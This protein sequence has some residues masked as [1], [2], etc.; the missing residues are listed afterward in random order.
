MNLKYPESGSQATPIVCRKLYGGL[1]NCGG[2]SAMLSKAKAL[3][4]FFYEKNELFSG[5]AMQLS[6]E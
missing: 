6:T 2:H 5:L 4:T 1:L 3:F